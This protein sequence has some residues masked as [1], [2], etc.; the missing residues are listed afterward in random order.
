MGG[1][2]CMPV[3]INSPAALFIGTGQG[4]AIIVLVFGTP[5]ASTVGASRN[6]PDPG[7]DDFR[8][9]RIATRALAAEWQCRSVASAANMRERERRGGR[10][11]AI[12]SLHSSPQRTRYRTLSV[13]WRLTRK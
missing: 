4:P 5:G 10:L 12:V 11:A 9:R 7:Q 8:Q 1:T 2:G 3:A 6:A 13:Y